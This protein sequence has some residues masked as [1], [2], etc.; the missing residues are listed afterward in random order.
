MD[1]PEELFAHERA[2][3]AFWLLMQKPHTASELAGK[4]GVTPRAV[5]MMLKKLAD[6]VPIHHEPDS[7]LWIFNPP[8]ESTP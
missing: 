6:V 8:A 3:L 4:I 7:G 5:R 2:A 1:H